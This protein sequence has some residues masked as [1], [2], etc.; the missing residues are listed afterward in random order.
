M[1]LRSGVCTGLR[2]TFLISRSFAT[3]SSAPETSERKEAV[4]FDFGA[5]LTLGMKRAEATPT[6]PK[7]DYFEGIPFRSVAEFLGDGYLSALETSRAEDAKVKKQRRPSDGDEEACGGDISFPLPPLTAQFVRH[8]R[9]RDTF[10]VSKDTPLRTRL[11]WYN[12]QDG[13]VPSNWL[14]DGLLADLEWYRPFRSSVGYT[15]TTT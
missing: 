7:K 3:S 10:V 1:L 2:N 5:R 4:V 8:D 14:K 12:P 11:S 13:M 15:T 6:K 9:V